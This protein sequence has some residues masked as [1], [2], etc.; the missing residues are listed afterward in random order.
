MTPD[1]RLFAIPAA[2]AALLCLTP[3]T[4]EALAQGRAQPSIAFYFAA[5]DM[6]PRLVADYLRNHPGEGIRMASLTQQGRDPRQEYFAFG[7]TARS[8]RGVCRFSVT[9]M[10]PHE[11]DSQITWDRMP[12]NTRDYV[13]PTY[14][15]GVVAPGMCPRQDDTSYVTL[16]AD[17]TDAELIELV[18][19][20][21]DV[22][23]TQ[24][25]FDAVSDILPL[26]LSNRVGMLFETFR[27]RIFEQG[28][29]QPQLRAVLRHQGQ[30]Y[31]LGFSDGPGQGT[32]SFVTVAKSVSGY[33]M[34]DFQTY[35][36]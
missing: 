1:F 4:H 6:T 26:I 28:D 34:L 17:I 2:I 30:G 10:F 5:D 16:D 35:L 15:M 23:S 9:Q 8:P 13:Q 3:Q 33:S 20:W 18:A 14:A 21:K 12:A 32:S 22:T 11:T 31:D 27:M 19:F 29:R 24:A 36:R 7:A 25:K